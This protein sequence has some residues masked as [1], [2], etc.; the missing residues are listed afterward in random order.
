MI[1]EHIRLFFYAQKA[2]GSFSKLQPKRNASLSMLLSLVRFFY[3]FSSLK[4]LLR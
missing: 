3:V 1:N 2:L 4:F